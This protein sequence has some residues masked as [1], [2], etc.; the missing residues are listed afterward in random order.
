MRRSGVVLV[1]LLGNDDAKLRAETSKHIEAS[2]V[3]AAHEPVWGDR[4]KDVVWLELFAPGKG[5]A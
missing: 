5:G 1:K 3:E 2:Y 4:S